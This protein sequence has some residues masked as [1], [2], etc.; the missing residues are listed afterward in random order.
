MIKRDI[1][2]WLEVHNLQDNEWLQWLYYEQHHWIP[3]Y[4]KNTFWVV[5][6]TTLC[7]ES[8]NAF[9]DGYVGPKTTLKQFADQYDEA[10]KSKVERRT[11]KILFL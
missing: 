11:R 1:D 5:M 3:T 7:S 6:S 10:L 4:V 2:C 8:M 9:F